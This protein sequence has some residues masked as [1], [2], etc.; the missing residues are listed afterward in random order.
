MLINSEEHWSY[1]A[2]DILV[3]QE[4]VYTF[5]FSSRAELDNWASDTKN[6]IADA[7]HVHDGPVDTVGVRARH[8]VF[9]IN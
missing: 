2:V 3:N 4:F 9:S 1:Y 6:I 5:T 7:E 8:G